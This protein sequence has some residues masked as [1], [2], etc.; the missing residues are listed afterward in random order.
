MNPVKRLIDNNFHALT[1]KNFRYFWL[2]QCVSLIGTW[3]QSIGQ[4]WLVY[5]LTKSP[6]LLGL[7]GA[8]QFLPVT[9]LSL[10]AGVFIDKYPKKRILLITQCSS[11]ILA[12][13]LAT[14]VFTNTV[15]YEYI[16][17]IAV[18]LGITNSIDMPAR[19]SF[20]IEIVG[21]EDLMNAVALNSVIFNLA[22]VLGPSIGAILMAAVG[23]GWCFL[24]NGLSFIAVLYGLLL[25]KVEP[26]VREKKSNN[27]I[28]EIKDGLRYVF[29]QKI[30]L[31]P[32]LLVLVIGILAFNYNVI[33]PVFVKNVLHAEADTYGILMAALGVG[34]VFGALTVSGNN[35]SGPKI[36]V[37][38][39]SSLVIGTLFFVNGVISQYFVTII[40]LAVI[41]AFSIYFSTTANTILQMN[42]NDEYRGR[43]MSVYSMSFSGATPIGSLFTGAVISSLGVSNT[44]KLSGGLIL[45]FTVFICLMFIS[46]RK[47]SE[48]S[49]LKSI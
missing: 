45:F 41:G 42:S 37:M 34:S 5:T 1:H 12:L 39:I 31:Q 30:L 15:K 10:F 4:A 19:Q 44:F 20:M 21:R 14:L 17:I 23:A 25:I 46:K 9:L 24:L 32:I 49:N 26:Y 8:M 38:I 3:T 22:K 28:K 43:V 29:K 11:M 40:I 36:R 48:K 35:K 33:L 47:A 6:F 16:M 7:L 18:L 2:G 27:V 13:A